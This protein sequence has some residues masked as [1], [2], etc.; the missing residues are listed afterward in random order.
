MVSWMLG[1]AFHVKKQCGC[2]K[3]RFLPKRKAMYDGSPKGRE[4]VQQDLAIRTEKSAVL[5]NEKK[6]CL[7]LVC[8]SRV[9]PG[10]CLHVILIGQ[11]T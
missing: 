4:I 6:A 1:T 7:Q 8:T 11:R 3:D 10:K 2:K 9:T 5:S